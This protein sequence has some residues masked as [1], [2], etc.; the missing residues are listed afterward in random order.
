MDQNK[1]LFYN[2]LPRGP[3][4]NKPF[5]LAEFRAF[6][7]PADAGTIIAFGETIGNGH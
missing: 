1:E 7:P 2:I 3:P 5:D 4:Y 6:A